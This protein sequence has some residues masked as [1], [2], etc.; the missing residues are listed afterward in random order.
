MT[1]NYDIF[2]ADP[3]TPGVDVD[4]Q[5]HDQRVRKQFARQL[6]VML[7]EAGQD[8]AAALVRNERTDGGWP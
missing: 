6:A 3:S 7:D 1:H 5:A 8:Y 2:R 4:E